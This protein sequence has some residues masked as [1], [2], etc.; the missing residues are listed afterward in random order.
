MVTASQE[1]DCEIASTR[2][3]GMPLAIATS[4]AESAD[5]FFP[6]TERRAARR[7]KIGGKVRSHS[8]KVKLAAWDGRPIGHSP[9]LAQI[10]AA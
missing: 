9:P 3:S 7:T 1:N 5:T 6:A 4:G 8:Q 2:E 10:T